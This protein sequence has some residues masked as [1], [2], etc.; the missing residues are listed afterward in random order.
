MMGPCLSISSNADG[1]G[2]WPLAK[3]MGSR[4]D[5]TAPSY[6]VSPF[7]PVFQPIP[8]KIPGGAI[9][10]SE[11]AAP[12]SSAWCRIRVLPARARA[13]SEQA[14]GTD[15]TCRVQIP[16]GISTKTK[17]RQKKGETHTN[18][19]RPGARYS[20]FQPAMHAGARHDARPSIGFIHVHAREKGDETF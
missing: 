20:D 13:V 6:L 11:P 19:Y 9:L 5:R 4:N 2:H 7:C 16:T 12:G 17:R 18:S 3:S 15:R 10:T 8:A 1:V 14:R